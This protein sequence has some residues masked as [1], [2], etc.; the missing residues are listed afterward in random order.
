MPI[1]PAKKTDKDRYQETAETLATLLQ[2]QTI[3]IDSVK[4]IDA[5][6]EVNAMALGYIYG[7]TDCALRRAKLDVGSEHAADVLIFLISEFEEANVDRL[8]EYI[9][10]PSDRIKLMGGVMLG[11]NDYDAWDKSHHLMIA[12]RWSQCFSPPPNPKSSRHHLHLVNL[13]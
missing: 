5:G 3:F 10:S 2:G 13:G 11:R 9:R 1:L 12:L 4:L 7:L 8:Y 6:N